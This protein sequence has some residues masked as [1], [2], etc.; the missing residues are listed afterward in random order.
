MKM[1]DYMEQPFSD[2]EQLMEDT[3]YPEIRTQKKEHKRFGDRV[4]L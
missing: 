4:V 2:E 3:D 1:R